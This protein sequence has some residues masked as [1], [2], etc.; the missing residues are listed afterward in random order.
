M[1]LV[2]SIYL[3]AIIVLIGGLMFVNQTIDA[4][5]KARQD[6]SAQSIQVKEPSLHVKPY[7]DTWSQ[8]QECL[9]ACPIIIQGRN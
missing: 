5:V 9:Q 2:I 3:I 7:V 4:R 8:P 1:K 6:Q